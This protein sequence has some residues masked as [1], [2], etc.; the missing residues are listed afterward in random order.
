TSSVFRTHMQAC[1]DALAPHTD[2][3]LLD[4]IQEHP[5]APT[6]DR[7]DVVQPVLFATMTS[8]AALW[9]S[10]GIQPHAVI[11][12]SQGEI[13]AAHTAGILTLDDAARIVTL[14]SQALRQL[15]GQGGM[16]SLP[17]PADQATTLIAP[18]N[19]RISIAAHN[20]PTTTIVSG[21]TQALTELT[22]TCTTQH[23]D[24]RTIP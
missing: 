6:L 16:V 10:H 12:H 13:A 11:G 19:N 2:W 21:D 20:G 1:A 8:L 15:S 22:T 14:R 18:W 5:D 23:I 24:A 9:Q 7:I 4:V 3:S 17:L